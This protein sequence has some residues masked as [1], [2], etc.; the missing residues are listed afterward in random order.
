M[1]LQ[2]VD[3]S[4]EVG[5]FYRNAPVETSRTEQRRV[6]G[7]RTVGGCQND[8]ALR[9]VKAV[10]LG[11]QLVQRLFPLVVAA[12]VLSA[13]TLFT[14]GVDLVDKD[15]TRG[16]FISLLEQVTHLCSAHAHEHLH[17]F[18]TGNGEERHVCLAGNCLCQ[19]RFTCSG[20]SYQQCALGHRCADLFVALRLVEIIHDLRQQFLCLFLAGNVLE[21]DAG[22][23]LH[24]DLG[25]AL[26]H[27][28]HHRAVAAAH[29]L[30]HLL[31]KEVE[32]QQHQRNGQ[33][34]AD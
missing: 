20:R 9:T 7:F 21:L 5:Q 15:D 11:Q 4:L 26:A 1:Y 13:V 2:N 3:T 10:H 32:H 25:V 29:T 12:A 33:N 6:K 16:F 19:Q 34:I 27:A 17:K 8:N 18:R 28:E 14:D 23:G 31:V 24:I 22:G 30:R